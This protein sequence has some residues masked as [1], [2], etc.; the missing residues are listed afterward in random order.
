MPTTEMSPSASRARVRRSPC[1]AEDV[2]TTTRTPAPGGGVTAGSSL[3]GR[4]S[5]ALAQE[6]VDRFQQRRLVERALRDVA[7]GAGL[8]PAAPVLVTGARGEDEHR[9]VGGLVEVPD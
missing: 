1:E 5:S 7:V 9:Y 4:S 2:T 8:E 3:P 6:T